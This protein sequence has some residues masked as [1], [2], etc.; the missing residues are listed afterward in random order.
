RD[1][2]QVFPFFKD[3]RRMVRTRPLDWKLEEA[4]TR[5]I[6]FKQGTLELTTEA[7]PGEKSGEETL[8]DLLAALE[9]A[10]PGYRDIELDV[11][12]FMEELGPV[13]YRSGHGNDGKRI[14]YLRA[15]FVAEKLEALL[16]LGVR[17]TGFGIGC[18]ENWAVPPS[19]RAY[20][21]VHPFQTYIP[22]EHGYRFFPTFYRNLRDTLKRTPIAEDRE[23][24][25]E[26]SR[27]VFDNLVQTTS[28][29]VN[30]ESNPPDNKRPYVLPR[31][32]MASAEAFFKLLV[33]SLEKSDLSLEDTNR[34]AVKT[35]KFMTSCPERR[36]KEYENLSWWDFIGG[37]DYSPKFQEYL[38]RV[39][40]AFVA[41]TAK[42]CDARTYG[43]ISLQL[44]RD[45]FMEADRTDPVLNGPTSLAWFHV[46]RKYLESQG[47][48]FIRGKLIDFE[49]LEGVTA[50]P[51]VVLGDDI[52]KHEEK[53]EHKRIVVQAGYCVLALNIEAMQKLLRDR[54][55][56]RRLPGE[57]FQKIRDLD[58]GDATA[59]RPGGVLRHLTGMQF[60]FP[61]EI[62]FL[63]GHTVFPDS[64]WGLSSIYQPQFSLR[65][66]GWWDG[67]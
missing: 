7:E 2:R 65:K 9:A 4:F 13:P 34:L 43:G 22:G 11:R 54:D 67:Y 6:R 47:V 53:Q 16:P 59:E 57:D 17:T 64:A 42:E 50:W 29:G 60:Y 30:F 20:V 61:S 14:D 55:G 58:L 37:G 48:K 35:F 38:D 31:R 49:V 19:H 52:E 62:R 1:Q 21:E 23:T 32:R 39:A 41:M 10:L 18:A 36:A 12:G 15:G 27:S 5:R 45:Q 8:A 26:T 28:Q 44:Y 33:E 24:F 3:D 40:Q 56:G 63:P 51:V 46:W 25:V 66:R